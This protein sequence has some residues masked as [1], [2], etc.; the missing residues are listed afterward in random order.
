[1]A[2][3]A[4]T[5]PTSNM[6]VLGIPDTLRVDG[7]IPIATSVASVV[8]AYTESRAA[9]FLSW[10]PKRQEMLV[11]TRFGNM[12]QVHLVRSPLGMRKQ[13]TFFDEPITNASFPRIRDDYFVF[14]KDSGGNEFA[15]LY[16]YDVAS[17]RV[18]LLTDGGRTQHSPPMWSRSD[19]L[20]A[21]TSTRR[22]GTDRDLYIMDPS[23]PK[24]TD[25]LLLQVTGGGWYYPV[26]SPDDKVIL[27]TEF[28]SVNETHLWLIDV[29]TG[30]K[31]ELTPRVWK[32]VAH[33]FSAQFSSDGTA[34]Y[35]TSDRDNEFKRLSKINLATKETTHLTND[36]PHDVHSL[37][38]SPDGRT[39]A[40]V[41]NEFGCGRLYL[42]DT[43]SGSQRTVTGLPNAV[44]GVSGGVSWHS[45]SQH[46]AFTMQHAR[47]S[48]DVYVLHASHK[49]DNIVVTRWTESELGGLVQSQLS[50]AELVSWPSFDELTIHGFLYRPS[51][52][53]FPGK[54][55]VLISIHGGPE[56]AAEPVFQGRTNYFINELGV[57]LLYPNVRGSTGF[58]KTFV[59]LDCGKLREDSVKDI[60]ALLDWIV[61]QPDLDAD[62][63]MVYGNSYGGYMSLACAV[64]FSSR[65]RCFIDSVGIS[66]WVTFLESTESYRRDLRRPKYGDERD[67]DMRA[68]LLSISPQINASRI[69]R[70][71]FI[72]QGTN[73]P[74]VPRTESL[75]M[76]KTIRDNGGLVWYLEGLNEGHGFRKKP[77]VDYMFCSMIE[78]ARIHLLS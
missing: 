5:G 76:V 13:L 11:S 27:I 72:I 48:L 46:M 68:F 23:D 44:V 15:Q 29:R 45:D 60:G 40:F 73:D 58:G 32:G 52:K 69:L 1:M 20:V 7:I 65:V 9:D 61:R 55:P 14:L 54:H 49:T 62:R 6:S 22:N 16:R 3:P 8:R 56:A 39:L 12:A 33:G 77:N 57:A 10:H 25:R 36:I 74:R 4:P 21:Y 70:P 24:S 38:L 42:M 19:D 43:A 78:F 2:Q 51:A 59:S 66:N 18:T 26:W 63:I 47:S 37:A 28:V 71:L 35:V 41:V 50:E 31:S 30:E 75:Q 64:H 34:V 17:G 67:P 53:L